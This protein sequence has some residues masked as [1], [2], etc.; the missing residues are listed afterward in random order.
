MKK[1]KALMVAFVLAGMTV[2]SC[3]SDDSGPA[4]TIDG[5]WNQDKTIVKITNGPSQTIKYTGNETGCD[6]DYL[7]FASAGVFNDVIFN[8]NG[9]GECLQTSTLGTWVK[10]EDMLTINDAGFLSGTYEILKLSGSALQISTT[11]QSAGTSTT[12]TIYL[13]KAN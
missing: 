7:E 11:S 10:N 9:G 1:I 5:Q 3:S 2:V 6:K 8:K 12:T 13:K 4:A